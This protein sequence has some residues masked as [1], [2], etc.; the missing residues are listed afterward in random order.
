MAV[1]KQAGE[2]GEL[3]AIGTVVP[4]TVRNKIVYTTLDGKYLG[5]VEF[6]AMSLPALA[7]VG[8]R[9]RDFCARQASKV[10]PAGSAALDILR[11]RQ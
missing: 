5:A 6:E 1:D 7:I 8:E 9:F 10:T 11:R 3:E 2:A 4:G